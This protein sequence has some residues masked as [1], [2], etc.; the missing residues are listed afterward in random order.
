MHLLV[1]IHHFGWLSP[2]SF[3]QCIMG[4]WPKEGVFASDKSLWCLKMLF[5]PHRQHTKFWNSALKFEHGWALRDKTAH[6]FFFFFLE[7]LLFVSLHEN[8]CF[9]CQSRVSDSD[10]FSWLVSVSGGEG[11]HGYAPIR[12][13]DLQLVQAARNMRPLQ[14]W[15]HHLHWQYKLFSFPNITLRLIPDT[16]LVQ[17]TIH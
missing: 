15:F 2:L 11:Q 8:H 13:S 16:Q 1:I 4:I 9:P 14:V 17:H 12:L 5:F 6:H 3:L 10:S 7:A